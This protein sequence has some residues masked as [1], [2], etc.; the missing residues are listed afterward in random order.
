MKQFV[1]ILTDSNRRSLHVGLTGDL[2]STVQFYKRNKQLF[3]DSP[4][5]VSR[6]VYFE[7]YDREDIALKRF[8]T[9][10]IYTRPQKERIIRA[11]NTDWIDLSIGLDMERMLTAGVQLSSMPRVFHS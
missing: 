11:I 8:N 2:L 9:L 7:E 1:Y 5:Q 10:K 3:F 4:N 6:L